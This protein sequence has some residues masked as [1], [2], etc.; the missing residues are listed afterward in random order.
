M[1]VAAKPVVTS[2]NQG[3]IR[4]TLMMG[5]FLV[6]VGQE[7]VTLLDGTVGQLSKIDQQ[8]AHMQQILGEQERFSRANRVLESLPVAELVRESLQ[9]FSAEL[10]RQIHIKPS[11]ELPTVDAVVGSRVAVQQIL[12]NLLKNAVAAVKA[13][14]LPPGIGHIAVDASLEHNDSGD[15]VH[16]RVSDNGVGLS[17][18]SLPHIF[19]RGF[20]TKG[21]NSSGI[22]LH[23]CAIT[24]LAMGGTLYAERTGVGQGI[25]LH[26]LLPHASML[27]TGD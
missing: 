9:L 21:R 1:L 26:L 11:P 20:S 16:L 24:T 14:S 22:G 17:P 15:C 18:E 27:A 25:C 8:I 23:W 5:R 13:R 3:L 4:G 12:I 10:H 2:K 7:M 6:L 19:E